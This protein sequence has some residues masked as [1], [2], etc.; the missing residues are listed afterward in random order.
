VTGRFLGATFLTGVV[1]FSSLG[2]ASQPVPD[3][4]TANAV[5]ALAEELAAHPE[6]EAAD[7]Y[8]FLHQAL[9][10]PGHAITDRSAAAKYLQREI[11][12][13]AEPLESEPACTTLGGE[14]ILVRVHLRLFTERGFDADELLDAFVATAREVHGEASQMD[15]AL[16]VVGEFLLK[17]GRPDLADSLKNLGRLMRSKGYPAVHHSELYRETYRPAYRIVDAETAA[18]HGWCGMTVDSR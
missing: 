14:P 9:F 13:L 11:S 10:G 4:G 17:D 2:L 18:S 1:A 5:Q 15:A 12:E 3:R 7:I 8:K 6:M 16:E